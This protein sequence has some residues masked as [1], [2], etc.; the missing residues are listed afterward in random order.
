MDNDRDGLLDSLDRCPNDAEDRDGYLDEDGCPDLDDD[1]DGIPDAVDKCP[2]EPENR[3]GIEDNDGCPEMDTDGDGIP[4][5]RDKCPT[6]DE[7]INFYQDEDGCPDEKPEP[8]Q[9]GVLGGLEFD[10]DGSELQP[11]SF[12]ALDSLAAK[13]AAYPGTEIEIQGHLDDRS[14]PNAKALSLARAEA[15]AEYLQSKGVEARRL[16][17]AGY[18]SSR[19]A[20]PNRTANG[21][22]ANRRIQIHRLN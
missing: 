5:S 1:K 22:A 6:E 20:M 9:D 12:G 15:V 2:R 14:G 8:I 17:P 10:A 4:D 13:L 3:N 7:I 18:G 16:K 21:R 19:P 11:S